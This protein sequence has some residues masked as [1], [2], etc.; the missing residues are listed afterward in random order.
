MANLALADL[1]APYILRGDNL[2]AWHAALSVIR[3]TRYETA[4]D[5][6]GV[7]LR[8]HAEFNGQ[9]LV[10]IGSGSLSIA[11]QTSEAAPP[12]DP[13]RKDP[14]FD[15]AEASLDFELFVPR[16]GSLIIGAGEA[17]ITASSFAPT[18]DVLDVWDAQ[19]VS[20][21]PSDYPSSGFRLDLIVN[22]PAVRPPFL[23]PAKMDDRGLLIPDSSIKEVSLTLP[24]LRFRLTHA[25]ATGGQLTFELVSA[26]TTGLDDAGDIGDAQLISMNPPYA[27]IGGPKDRCV[28]IGFRKAILDLSNNVAPPEIVAKF[29]FGDD[30]GGL[31][32]PEMRI[33][34]APDGAEDLAI[35]AGV[36][37]LLIGFGNTRGISGDFELAVIDQ[38]AGP[39]V[40]GARFFDADGKAYGIERL[41]DTTAS[42]ALPAQTRMV[43]DVQGGLPPYTT[44]LKV[45]AGTAQNGRLFDVDLSTTAKSTLLI[46]AHDATS[47][48]AKTATLTITANLRTAETTL[49]T[50]GD[51]ATPAQ[52]ATPDPAVTDPQIVI[53]GQ[54]DTQV[55]LKTDPDN[56]QVLWSSPPGSSET[57]PVAAFTIALAAG[58]SKTVRARLPATTVPTELDY[59]FY[60]DEPHPVA[61]PQEEPSALGLYAAGE[62]NLGTQPAK[63]ATRADGRDP[64]NTS[65]LDANQATFDTQMPAGTA[66]KVFGEVSYEGDD[67]N[68]AL[69]YNYKL[70]RRRAI[71]V[72]EAIATRHAARNFT[73]TIDPNPPDKASYPD[74]TARFPTLDQWKANWLAHGGTVRR[75]FWRASIQLPPGLSQAEKH[76]DRTLTRP[77]APPPPTIEVK[78]PPATNPPAPPS[79]FRSAKLKVRIVQDVLVAVEVD[80]E[81]DFQTATEDSINATGQLPGG[82]APTKGQTLQNGQPLAPDNPADGLTKLKF[83]AQ[84]DSA[85]G[86]FQALI[87]IGADPADKD[88]LFAFGWLA[89][90]PRPASKDIWLTLAG[91]YLSFWPMLINLSAGNTG[92]IEGAALAAAELAIPGAVALIPWFRVERVIVFGGEYQQHDTPSGTVESFLLFDVE[93]DWS[94]DISIGGVDLITID[95]NFPLAVRYKAIGL[96][97]GNRA[98]DGS[99][100]HFSLKPVFDASRGFTIDVAR[101]GSIKV[102]SPFDKVLKILAARLSRTNPLT[103]EIDLGCAVDLGVVS[104]DRARLRVY[105]QEPIVPPELTALGAS[106]DIPGAIGG[107]GYLA[108]GSGDQPGTSKISGQL[109]VTIRPI[110]LRVAA[111]FEMQDVID[112]NDAT[113]HVTAIYVGLNVVLPVG[114]PLGTSG[115]GI[116]GFRGIFGM[117]YAR[118]EQLGA[119]GAAPALGWLAATEGQPHLIQSPVHHN[120]LWQPKIDNWAF[121]IGT[122]LG[123]M[124]GGFIINLDGTLLLELPGPRIAI[125]MNARIISPPPSL[126]GMGSSGGILA[127]I[128]ITPDHLLIGVLINY[129]IDG[130][131]KLTVP[132]ESFFSFTDSSDWHFYLGQRS[133]PVTVTVLDII[134]ATGY[135]MIK[136]NGLDALPDKGLPAIP[137]FAIGAGAAASFTWGDTGVGLYLRISGSFDAVIGFDPFLL[138]GRFELSGELHLFIVS[139]GASAKLDIQVVGHSG[140]FDTHIHGEACGHVDFFFFSV[141]GC[142]SITIGSA[143]AKPDLPDLV[144]K[145]SLKSR[146][147]ALLVGTGVD[148]PIDTSLGE[149]VAQD[150]PPAADDGQ[151]PVVPI[152]TVLVLGMALPPQAPGLTFMGAGVLGSTSQAPGSFVQRG[153]ESFAYTLSAVTL[154]R[155]DGGPALLGSNAPATWWTPS[156]AS[157]ANVNAQLALL[158]WEADPATK[159]FEKTEQRTQQIK[160]RWSRICEDA[161]PAARVLWTFLDERL[162]PS[163][164]GWELAGVAWPDPPGTRRKQPPQTELLVGEAWRSGDP[165]IDA[166]RGILPATVVGGRI[167]C[168]RVGAPGTGRVNPAVLAK[169]A[170]SPPLARRL[171]ALEAT[172]AA[173]QIARINAL[174]AAGA[175]AQALMK[176][177]LVNV[178]PTT[179]LDAASIARRVASGAAVS[180]VEIAAAFLAPSVAPGTPAVGV[181]TCQ[182]QVLQSPIFDD[183]RIIV[184]GNP[185][186]RN[187][188]AQ[189]LQK[190]GIKHGKLNDVVVLHL[191]PFN[192]ANVL[193]FVRRNFLEGNQLVMRV[194]DASGAELVRVAATA[195]DMVAAKPLPAH[196]TDPTGPWV[197]DVADVL[198]WAQDPRAGGYLP[199]WLTI[200]GGT[201]ADRVE[202]GLVDTAHNENEAK[203][204]AV[205][206]GM[207]PPYFLGAVDALSLAEAARQDSEQTE[208]TNERK[209]ITQILGPGETDDAYLVPGQLYKVTAT[210]TGLRQSDNASAGKTQTFWF[211]SDA[212]PPARLDPWVLMTTPSDGEAHAFRL[213]P[214]RIVFN[215]HNVNRLFAAYGKELRVR[216]TASSANHPKPTAAVPHPFPIVA[217][218][219]QAAGA[220]I[221][222][223]WEDA[224]QQ[225]V[226]DDNLVCI[227]LDG[228]RTRQS[229]VD[230]PILLDPYTDYHLDVEMVDQGAPDDA[231]GTRIYRR[232]FSTGAY[233]SLSHFA[234][235]LQS[236]KIRHRALDKGKLDAVRTFFNGRQ[237][238]GSELDDQLRLAGFEAP[239]RP[240]AP[241]IA[242]LWEQSGPT[243]QPVGVLVDALEPLWRTRPHP[244]QVTDASGPSTA[245]RWVMGTR[246]W[247]DVELG[248]TSAA[249]IAAGGLIRAPGDQRVL[250]V[251]TPGNR[252]KR[253][254]LE[255]VQPASTDA[256]M[257]FPEER[258]A[259]VDLT[260]DKAAWEE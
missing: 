211:S 140:A 37:D 151:L 59:F 238:Q 237:P 147:P 13:N 55:T 12:F 48:M 146:S 205:G 58:E 192:D 170:L 98:D 93:A 201:K 230:I 180:R 196:W 42:V 218:K 62:D 21:P 235:D 250:V 253:L 166:K 243:P 86:N 132:V 231:V 16:A 185:A 84:K 254:S 130:L 123:T 94:V 64:G 29:G 195:A 258:H 246:T 34:I 78:D 134:K 148:R 223:P 6:F 121:G 38:G 117:H 107:S 67:G 95:P 36:Q 229:V 83:L 187:T 1:I 183:G 248:A 153:S 120:I 73:F 50:P 188:V 105:L 193:L 215:T 85:T 245:Q 174:A 160:E 173:P 159:A 69:D 103:F 102:A 145:L 101:G 44:S 172:L 135:L 249:A 100:T 26:G 149:A 125:V 119:G 74:A 72:R 179:T 118:N 203:K 216:F 137:G 232:G 197:N 143:N 202:I 68:A 126:D 182:T 88:G 20:P 224:L 110:S 15:L 32:L 141:E 9:G 209:V 225:A 54:N 81:I 142:V 164:V 82:T 114:I 204:I 208:I 175:G 8:G 184:F 152:D 219:I 226:I 87:Q 60:F 91:S 161:A 199:V 138:A 165:Q 233:D 56:A 11:G 75:Q 236:T 228:T 124:E 63:T 158:T 4:S 139:I 212:T 46:T 112:P 106:I 47:G 251:L 157:S 169:V 111:A 129:N 207:V 7:A 200:K 109:D 178:I 128:E 28:G 113:H 256:Y 70:A 66:L 162:G 234:S 17:T 227:P 33:F 131:I 198:G 45:D 122:L 194:L 155:A 222:S 40:L 51:K 2:G 244:E 3:V 163:P 214:I 239:D 27:F 116:F 99:V 19:P 77:P 25:N 260:L 96:R 240:L 156:D 206:M 255:L 89:G 35:E 76:G 22:A 210:W 190:A 57:G 191:G 167:K 252:G 242:V 127:I 30:W 144:Q 10:D 150:A 41:T 39:L 171:H 79:W 71:A 49:P 136:G 65:P 154:E 97:F 24:R 168:Q 177:S 80:M 133:N 259:I 104:I 221:L 43:I 115:L 5:D 108:I 257:P 247:L 189:A 18:K 241:R 52:P 217:A 176:A 14:V 90:Q 31:Y 23:Q 181:G 186:D 220:G 61:N 213:D 92:G 53:A